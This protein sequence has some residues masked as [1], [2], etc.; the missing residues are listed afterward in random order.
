MKGSSGC[1]PG[2]TATRALATYIGH[3]AQLGVGLQ[4]TGSTAVAK[5][6]DAAE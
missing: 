4:L 6:P 2:S 5:A 3:M 1:D